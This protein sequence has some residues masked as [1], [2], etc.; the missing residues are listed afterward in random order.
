MTTADGNSAVV[1]LSVESAMMLRKKRTK[2]TSQM[3]T[4]SSCGFPY[5]FLK[6]GNMARKLIRAEMTTAISAS[7]VRRQRTI[8]HNVFFAPLERDHR[9]AERTDHA[10][11]CHPCAGAGTIQHLSRE[12]NDVDE[13]VHKPCKIGRA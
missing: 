5:D 2:S 8:A 12:Y 3:L 7:L 4:D 1:K 6:V 11:E 13:K 9:D 10:R